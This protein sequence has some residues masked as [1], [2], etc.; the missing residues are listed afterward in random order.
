MVK[1]IGPIARAPLSAAGRLDEPVETPPATARLAKLSP[2]DRLHSP[3]TSVVWISDFGS[4][5]IAANVRRR[6]TEDHD[7]GQGW[8]SGEREPGSRNFEA[9]V[10]GIAS[11]E[12]LGMVPV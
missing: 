7:H 11:G 3:E 12:Y 9:P 1:G 6:H 2:W 5:R 8:S 10:R 4:V